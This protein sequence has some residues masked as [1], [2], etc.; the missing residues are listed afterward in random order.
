MEK[1]QKEMDAIT[2]SERNEFYKIFGHSKECSLAKDK[3]GYY[4]RTHRARSKSYE[5]IK[6]IPK[7]DVDF[8]RSTS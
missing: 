6:D 2:S 8:V 5:N 3:D 7:K 4:V 1:M